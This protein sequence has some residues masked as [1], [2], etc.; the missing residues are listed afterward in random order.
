MAISGILL[1]AVVCATCVCANAYSDA[2]DQNLRSDDVDAIFSEDPE[3]ARMLQ[4][5][6]DDAFSPSYQES[7]EQNVDQDEE[8][9]TEACSSRPRGKCY[10]TAR[11][12]CYRWFRVCCRTSRSSKAYC[13]NTKRFRQNGALEDI[14]AASEDFADDAAFA[15]MPQDGTND[16]FSPSFQEFPEDND[17]QEEAET[18][19]CNVSFRNYCYGKFCYRYPTKI[20][21]GSPRRCTSVGNSRGNP[22][23]TGK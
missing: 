14:D 19:A 3:Y 6:L 21:C 23:Y 1:A 17:E 16:P 10:G 15:E 4:A 13:F 12:V 2:K 5:D 20:C 18:E 22:F 11:K 8:A 7:P 9:E